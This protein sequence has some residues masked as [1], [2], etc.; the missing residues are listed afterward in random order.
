[1]IF[2]NR[3]KDRTAVI[4][5]GASGIGEATARRIAAEGGRVALFDVNADRLRSVGEDIG[6]K[7]ALVDISDEQQVRDAY[8]D[9]TCFGQYRRRSP[10]SP[11][12]PLGCRAEHAHCGR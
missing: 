9:C 4:T 7:T 5:G 10:L 11:Q 2:A 8:P 3:F 12:A 6:A 1:M